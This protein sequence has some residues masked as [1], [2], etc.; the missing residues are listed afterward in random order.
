MKAHHYPAS[1][2][3]Y[4]IPMA[5]PEII[6]TRGYYDM[7]YLPHTARKTTKKDEWGICRKINQVAPA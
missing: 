6:P 3:K 7:E 1:E 5:P 2:Y 4:D